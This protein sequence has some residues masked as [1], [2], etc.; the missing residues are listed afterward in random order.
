MPIEDAN[1]FNSGRSMPD[2]PDLAGFVVVVS[3]T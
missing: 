2:N 1:C 3:V